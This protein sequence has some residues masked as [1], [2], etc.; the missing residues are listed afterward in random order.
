MRKGRKLA[1]V[2]DEECLQAHLMPVSSWRKFLLVRCRSL[3]KH[4][5]AMKS[6]SKIVRNGA[7]KSDILTP[8]T[9]QLSTRATF[10]GL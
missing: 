2:G 4:Q 10:S 5:K 1:G 7:A 8:M 3:S 6:S 9:Q